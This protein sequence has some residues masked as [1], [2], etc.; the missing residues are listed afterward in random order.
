MNV[1]QIQTEN[2]RV[3]TYLLTY[4][5]THGVE[6]FLRSCQMSSHSRMSQYFMEPEGSLPPSQKPSTGPYPEP[7]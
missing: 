4:L 3:S 2:R 1:K 5:L 6:A 7:D